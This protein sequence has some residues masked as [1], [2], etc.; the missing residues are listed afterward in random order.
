MLRVPLAV[1]LLGHPRCLI[2]AS[3]QRTQPT[4]IMTFPKKRTLALFFDLRDMNQHPTTMQT[5]GANLIIHILTICQQEG[6]RH[7]KPDHGAYLCLPASALTL[8]PYLHLGS[9]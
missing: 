6:G 9:C 8:A 5:T 7:A 1:L 4:P 3:P 2:V